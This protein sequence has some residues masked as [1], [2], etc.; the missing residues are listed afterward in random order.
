MSS[1]RRRAAV[2]GMLL[3]V[4]MLGGCATTRVVTAWKSPEATP[5]KLEKVLVVALVPQ[6]A[7]RRNLEDRLVK[8]LQ[9]TGAV[10][11]PS[12]KFVDEGEKING[13]LVKDLAAREGFD[14]VLVA[15]HVGT[16]RD[17]EY[18]YPAT[19]YDYVGAMAPLVYGPGYIEETARVAIDSR[20]FD[21][22]QG[23]KLVWAMSTETVEGQTTDRSLTSLA[24][25]IVDRLDKDL[26]L[27]G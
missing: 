16:R 9:R 3:S 1:L 7:I 22:R 5:P 14:A 27:A 18:A 20:L 10:A 17:I 13:E 8:E 15:R 11:I 21:A 24:K 2:L 26:G 4:F 25:K 19:Y 23:G 12:S 6:E